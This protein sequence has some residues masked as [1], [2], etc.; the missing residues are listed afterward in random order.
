MPEMSFVEGIVG[1]LTYRHGE[2]SDPS[3]IASSIQQKIAE[4]FQRYET[5]SEAQSG[6]LPKAVERQILGILKSLRRETSPGEASAAS[7]LF[8]EAY[9]LI[10]ESAEARNMMT[11]AELWTGWI[12]ATGN[13]PTESNIE[14]ISEDFVG[15]VALDP[16]ND[17]ILGNL[18]SFYDLALRLRGPQDRFGAQLVK[19]RDAVIRLRRA[20][21]IA[22]KP[23]A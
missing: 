6:A 14:K 22:P 7:A 12:A 13:W 9:G 19:R 2:A 20:N 21:G 5:A 3:H 17:R 16:Q 10:P 11:C 4:S 15:A 8:K 18:Q 1:Y 23:P